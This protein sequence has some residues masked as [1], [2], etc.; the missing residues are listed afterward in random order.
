[1]RKER[2]A[3][4]RT[5]LTKAAAWANIEKAAER[6]QTKDSSL[7]KEQAIERV[8]RSDEGPPL[9]SAYREAIDYDLDHAPET[10]APIVSAT[11]DQAARRLDE[12][13]DAL[14]RSANIS[15]AHAYEVTLTTE[16]GRSLLDR[17][18]VGMGLR[19]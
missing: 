15:K 1:M 4:R 16:E 17:Y 12:M 2:E 13:A 14:A 7:S 6:L 8:V 18:R 10:P 5:G 9:V 19:S 3:M 11:A